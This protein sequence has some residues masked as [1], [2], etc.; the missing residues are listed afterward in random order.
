MSPRKMKRREI[1][2]NLLII[3]AADAFAL[4]DGLW[5]LRQHHLTTSPS[6]ASAASVVMEASLWCFTILST[7]MCLWSL[8]RQALHNGHADAVPMKD[9]GNMQCTH[10]L[11]WSSQHSL[12]AKWFC[13]IITWQV[14]HCGKQSRKSRVDNYHATTSSIKLSYEGTAIP[15]RCAIMKVKCL[16]KK[17]YCIVNL[18]LAHSNFSRCLLF[19]YTHP[20]YLHG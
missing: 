10:K 11:S 4:A 3:V 2:Y 1:H 19:P 16:Y 12:L 8:Y 6:Q 9:Y 13:P 17:K 15:G 5:S 20:S 7:V 14:R 18:F